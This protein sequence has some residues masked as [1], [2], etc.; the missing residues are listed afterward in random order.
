MH[1]PDGFLD[2]GTTTGAALLSAGAVGLALVKS[3]QTLAQRGP[4]TTGL[5]AVFIFAAQ[6]INFP[7]GPGTSGHLLG[8]AL[9]TVLVGPWLAI[10]TLT[11]VLAV[12]ALVFADGGLTALGANILLMAVVGVGVSYVVSRAVLAVLPRRAGMVAVAGAIAGFVSLIAAALTFSGLYAVGGTVDIPLMALVSAMTGWHAV[13]GIGEAII[14]GAVVS[15][16]VATRP[17]LVYLNVL[18]PA[19]LTLRTASGAV[20]VEPDTPEPTLAGPSRSFVA[21]GVSIS[22][23]LAGGLSLFASAHP[24]GLE[25]VAQLLGFESSAVDS[26]TASSPLADYVMSTVSHPALGGILAGLVGVALTWSA[27]WIVGYAGRARHRRQ[28][29]SAR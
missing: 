25:F 17:D 1:I 22:L 21:V 12:Q 9:A 7:V 20:E 6:M 29:I 2:I 10:L 3:N 13:I 4:A 24:D 16:V 5:A 28:V 11:V 27:A 18:R 15:A 19:S 8:A 23:L 26:V 14:T